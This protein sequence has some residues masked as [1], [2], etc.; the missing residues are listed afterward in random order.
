[1]DEGGALIVRHNSADSGAVARGFL[2]IA[3]FYVHALYGVFQS[4][5][6]DPTRAMMAGAQLKLLAPNVSAF[7]FLSGMAAPYFHRKGWSAAL[8]PSLTLLIL[9]AMSHVVAV[10]INMALDPQWYGPYWF[11]RRMLKPIV[12]GTGYENFVAWFLV[13]LAFA[14]AFAYLFLRSRSLF[15]FIAAM[16]ALLFWIGQKF[17]MPDN[18]YEWRNWPTATL[19]FLIGMRMPRDFRINAIAG[20]AALL[21]TIVLAWLNRPGLLISGPCLECELAFVAQPMIGQYGSL[22]IYICQQILFILFLWWVS[23]WSGDKMPGRAAAYIGNDSLSMLLLHGWVL[24]LIYPAAARSLPERESIFL[25]CSI[26]SSV[27]VAHAL[28]YFLLNPILRWFGALSFRISTPI[29]TGLDIT[30]AMI[31]RTGKRPPRAL[32]SEPA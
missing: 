25:F 9:A 13:A 26:L 2:L 14:R 28:L 20:W 31:L 23:V 19:F 3:V 1:M 11:A 12:L 24:V 7:F 8:K 21:G 4:M 32:P 17:G 29:M 6:S 22:P 18:I 10:G 5:D 30:T 15:L 16:M 27:L